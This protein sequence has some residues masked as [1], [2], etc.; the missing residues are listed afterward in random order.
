MKYRDWKNSPK[1]SSVI[2]PRAAETLPILS[3]TR[4]WTWKNTQTR[5]QRRSRMGCG[6]F[7]ACEQGVD[8]RGKAGLDRFSPS[9]YTAPALYKTFHNRGFF[10]SQG[11]EGPP[12]AGRVLGGRQRGEERGTTQV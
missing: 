12:E 7:G 1:I 6:R 4:W 10:L 8:R 3:V 2:K 9:V 11:T 5:I